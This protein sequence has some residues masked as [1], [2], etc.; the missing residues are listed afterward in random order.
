MTVCGPWDD[1]KWGHPKVGTLSGGVSSL[2]IK[3]GLQRAAKLMVLLFFRA[4]A[5]DA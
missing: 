3:N 5:A 4:H 2:K 1:L